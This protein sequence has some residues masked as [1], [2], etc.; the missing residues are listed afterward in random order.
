MD[1]RSDAFAMP[2]TF[3]IPSRNIDLSNGA[4]TEPN[5]LWVEHRREVSKMP[6]SQLQEQ[7]ESI[8]AD[9]QRDTLRILSNNNFDLIYSIIF[10]LEDVSLATRKDVL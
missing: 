2:I 8:M 1:R 3:R 10:H 7:L 6:A 5:V 4:P 9:I